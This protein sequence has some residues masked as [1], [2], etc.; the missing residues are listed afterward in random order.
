MFIFLYIT[1]EKRPRTIGALEVLT[2]A[3]KING[4]VG[5]AGLQHGHEQK[6]LFHQVKQPCKRDDRSTVG[7]TIK[8]AGDFI[9]DFSNFLQMSP[10]VPI[11]FFC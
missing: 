3:V 11:N 9:S 8:I 7:P 2:I 10:S 5:Q 4:A 6:F 1:K